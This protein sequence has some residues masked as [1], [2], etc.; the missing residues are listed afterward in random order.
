MRRLLLAGLLAASLAP[1]AAPAAG[2]NRAASPGPGAAWL[3]VPFVKQTKNGCGPAAIAMLLEYWQA[4]GFPAEAADDPPSI[5][6]A[7][8]SDA[9]QGTTGSAMRRYFERSG[10]RAFVFQGEWSDL[11]REIGE[12]RPLIVALGEPRSFHYAVV[13]GVDPRQGLVLL[14][15]PAR[16][17]LVKTDRTGFERAW[18]AAG[19][20]TL[21]AV[22]GRA[23]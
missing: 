9:A 5:R 10:F 4:H 14:N 2:A 21:L 12:G 6:A 11:E 8:Y 23:Q 3:D 13:A 1:V 22:P 7:V 18:N 15:D 17:K 20:W 16:R 19:R